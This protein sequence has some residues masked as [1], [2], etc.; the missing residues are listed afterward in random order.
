MWDNKITTGRD[1]INFIQK[2]ELEDFELKFTF[3]DGVSTF[4]NVRSFYNLEI[5]DI[6]HSSKLLQITGFEK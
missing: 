2:H 6:G 4:P 1:L 3:T 5:G